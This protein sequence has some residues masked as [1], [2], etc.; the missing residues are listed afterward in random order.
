MITGL[1]YQQPELSVDERVADLMKRMTVEEKVGQM[2][3]LPVFSDPDPVM[4]SVPVGSILHCDHDLIDH[5]ISKALNTRLGIPIIVA[6]D[7]IH[8]HSFWDGA[9]IFPTQLAQAC[10]WDPSLIGD[11]ARATAVEVAATGIHWTFS[12][13]LCIAR[14]TRWGRVD[15]TF[16][17]DP[18][19][20]GEMGAA[21][22]AGYQ[23][24]GPSDTSAVLACAKHFLAYSQTQ[25]G[26]DA[27]E[28]DLPP[29]SI[30]SWFSPPFERAAHAG[31]STFMLGYQAIDGVPITI[32]RPLIHDLLK[33]E[34]GFD[35][36]LVTDWDN[37]GRMVWEQNIFSSYPQAA[38]AAIEAGVDMAMA[39]NQFFG[40]TLEALDSGLV[41][42]DPIDEA[43]RRILTVKFSMG[44]FENPRRP[45]R[46]RQQAVIASPEHR[47]L[48]LEV[49][50]RSLVLLSNDGLLPLTPSASKDAPFRIS[51][52]G[53]NCD[54][55]DAQLG[56]WARNSGQGM[57]FTGHPGDVETVAE[58]LHSLLPD[59]WELSVHPACRITTSAPD[60]EGPYFADGQ[61]RPP[62]T[63]PAPEDPAAMRKAL[64]AVRS[65]DVAVIVVGDN[66]TLTG[67]GRSTATLDLV[68]PQRRLLEDTIA[69][70]TPTVVV[71]ISS[72]PLVLP[73]CVENANALI[74][75]FNPGLR[76]GRA[77]AE[78]LLG[79]IEPTG[80]LPI[81]MPRHAG[82][83][84]V[85]YNLVRGTHGTRYAD[86]PFTPFMAFGE[87]CAYTT[88]HYEDAV[89]DSQQVQLGDHVAVT[90]TV[91]NDGDR[92]LTETVQVYVRHPVTPVTWADKELKG[93]RQVVVEPRERA[94]CRI[95]IPVNRC[96]I[97]DAAGRRVVPTGPCELLVGHSSIDEDLTRLPFTIADRADA[98]LD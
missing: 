3:Q 85:H 80:R 37:V 77:I 46:N 28:C 83:I 15:E 26:R 35:G 86:L 76:G 22:A 92:P 19:L 7:C 10:T 90:V 75:A 29:R 1:P 89:L 6:D 57:R 33:Q 67:E 55:R 63:A 53:P 72:K 9:T 93:F 39:T 95:E 2:T 34:W 98:A 49:A 78:L 56:D 61:P 84:P 25:G 52:V 48:N 54:D 17:E 50:R 66:T 5:C 65:A 8:G 24:S 38:A 27:S 60:P 91:V 18:W 70:G 81:S 44:L 62:I 30:R 58:G 36:L 79:L 71:V 4:D 73:R 23:G 31:I 96:S 12:P 40:A 74:Q 45:D 16:G 13:V 88:F 82:Q 94:T 42:M 59:Q 69:S 21:M 64:N 41:T 43:V 51:L 14:D 47:D 87:G 97:V 20:I 11:A 32:N 68:G